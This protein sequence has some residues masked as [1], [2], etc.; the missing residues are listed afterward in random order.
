M[1]HVL[2]VDVVVELEAEAFEVL[3]VV[4]KRVEV[5]RSLAGVVRSLAGVARSPG[6]QEQGAARSL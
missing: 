5:V 2:Q 4:G 3:V 6:R 1:K